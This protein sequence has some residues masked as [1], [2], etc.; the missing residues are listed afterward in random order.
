M[1]LNALFAR[2]LIG[3][4]MGVSGIKVVELKTGKTPRFVAYN[5]I[6]LPWGAISSEGEIKN[7]EI[8]VKALKKLF[9]P[10]HFSSKSVAVAAF[11]NSII[12]K[13]ITVP[14]MS[15]EEL[16]HQLFWEAEQYIPFD[17]NDVN[18]DFAILGPATGAQGKPQ[19]EIL[20]VAAKKQYVRDLASVIQE[21]GLKPAIIDSQ[22]FALG[23]AFVYS[24]GEKIT[25][26]DPSNVVIDFGA[27]TTKVSVL[28]GSKT[29]FC[30][31][32]R[33]AGISCTEFIAERL[34]MSFMEA[35]SEKTHKTQFR[36]HETFD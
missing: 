17:I 27:G 11:G 8:V 2:E 5:R 15:R 9:R 29:V 30:R 22:A 20:L 34:D 13:K 16:Q 25:Q 4:D 23:N 26:E 21:A 24:Y 3:L 28:E 31:E 14:R 10:G 33:Q 7:R 35:E 6:A 18:L 12:V 32:L 1:D 36:G 19:M